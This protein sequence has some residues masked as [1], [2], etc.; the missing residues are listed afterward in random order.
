[1]PLRDNAIIKAIAK[2]ITKKPS[3]PSKPTSRK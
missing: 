1:M 2:I 3:K